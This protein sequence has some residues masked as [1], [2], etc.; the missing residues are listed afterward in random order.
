MAAPRAEIPIVVLS[1]ASP[2]SPIAG[3]TAFVKNRATSTLV[4]VYADSGT[5][6]N[7]VTQPLTTDSGGRLTGWLP[8]GSYLVE[9]TVSGKVPYTEYL[10]IATASDESIDG[11]W[12]ASEAI[13]AGKLG[14]ESVET[15]KIKNLA[16]TAGKLGSESVESGK[17]KNLAVIAGKLG[18]SSVEE[19]NIVDGAATSR[20]TRLTAD[21]KRQSVGPLALEA[22]YKDITGT[23]FEL[24]PS[25]ASN[26]IVTATFQ[27]SFTGGEGSALQQAIGTLNIDGSD[28]TGVATYKV[29]GETNLKSFSNIQITVSQSYIL[30]LTAIKH[31]MKL[32]AR[33]VGTLTIESF[34]NTSLAYILVAS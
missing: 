26:L 22:S 32:R 20:K 2:T 14:P 9:I 23:S 27:F 13:T 21:V 15:G 31:T 11:P 12:L 7:V 30:A 19:A 5:T 34:E 16:V 24:T 28:Q 25:V 33:K 17:I 3:A 4:N 10:E 18:S 6:E 29:V 1:E 8:R